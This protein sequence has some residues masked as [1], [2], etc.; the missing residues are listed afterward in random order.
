MTAVANAN[1]RPEWNP[2]SYRKIV[3]D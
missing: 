2:E 1:A 3:R